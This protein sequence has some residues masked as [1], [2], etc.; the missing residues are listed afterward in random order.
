MSLDRKA[1]DDL[2]PLYRGE[3]S[4]DVEAGLKRLHSRLENQE[5]VARTSSKRRKMWYVA[6]AAAAAV[7]LFVL[8]PFGDGLEHLTTDGAPIANHTLPDGSLIVLQQG[9]ELTYDPENFN[10]DDRKVSLSGQAYFEIESN[11]DRPFVID[12][13]RSKVTVTG[14]A[15]NLRADEA[16]M[17]VEV[18]EGTVVLAQDGE[19]LTLTAKELGVAESGEPMSFHEA[20]NLNHHAWRTGQLRFEHTPIDEVFDCLKSNW[21]IDCRWDDGE[22]CDYTVSASYH[23]IQAIEAIL[24]DIGQ[25]NGATVRAQGDK[26][27]LFS[28]GCDQ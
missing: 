19:N 9:G 17:E 22:S 1:I 16:L 26:T 10:V 28:G 7:L 14:T 21:G 13:G 4:P 24:R 8:L 18:S 3:Y 27:F 15:F 6:A 11:A 25:L 2:I 20:P 23:D 5:L 12:N